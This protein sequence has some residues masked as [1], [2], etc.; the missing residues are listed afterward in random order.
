MDKESLANKTINVNNEVEKLNGITAKEAKEIIKRL[1]E[2]VEYHSKLYYN[3]DITEISDYEYDI[4]MH[5]LKKLETDFP[6]LKRKNSIT[7]RVGGI[8]NSTFYKVLHEVKLQSLQDVF[9]YEELYEFDKRVKKDLNLKED[10]KVNYIV[11]TKIDGLSASLTYENGRLKLGATRGNGVEGEDLTNNF[12]VLKNLPQKIDYKGK[13]ILRG[14]VFISKE[15]FKTI[16]SLQAKE[17]KKLFANPRNAAAGSLRQKNINIVSERELQIYIF[18]IQY[19]EEK[20]KTHKEGIEFA[21]K[22]NFVVNPFLKTAKGIDEAIK[23]IEEIQKMRNELDFVIDGAVVK[24]DEIALREKL[25]TTS[26]YPKWAV[27]Y[28]YPPEQKEA[29]IDK[30]QLN[31][32]RTG[33]VSPLAIFKEPILLDGSMVS[34]ATLS[35]SGIINQKDVREKDVV[36][37]Q[38]AGD[39]IPEILKV[40][41]EKR[42][43]DSKA[44]KMP[45]FCPACNSKLVKQNDIYKCINTECEEINERKIIYFAS[46]EAMNIEN[47]R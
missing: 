10:E 15:D 13:I 29:I 26:K 47:L 2:E 16:N 20:F 9:S 44:F 23:K 32:G 36:I 35:N 19:C 6:K 46:K 34:R 17:K 40:V 38:K 42:P 11:E 37:V 8:P 39:V 7:E 27:A 41:L 4:L 22:N 43:K 45:E 30:I 33:V 1:Y 3:E 14:E 28:K 25:G 31:V 21:K 18:N 24:I 12:R 5:K